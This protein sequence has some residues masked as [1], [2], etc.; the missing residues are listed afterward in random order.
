[1]DTDDLRL[2]LDQIVRIRAV[3]QLNPAEALSF[4]FSLRAIV[5]DVIPEAVADVRLRAGLDQLTEK[6]DEVALAG[7]EVYAARREEVSKLRVD[8]VKRQV[9]WVMEKMNRSGEGPGETPADSNPRT[10]AYENVQREDLK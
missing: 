5:R 2:H 9:S 8:E 6:I 7:F 3:Q 1:M 10:S 4:V